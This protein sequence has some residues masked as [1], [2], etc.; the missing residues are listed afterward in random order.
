VNLGYKRDAAEKVI[1]QA[2]HEGGDLSVEVLLRRS[3]KALSK[4]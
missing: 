3:L 4:G 1:N 2:M